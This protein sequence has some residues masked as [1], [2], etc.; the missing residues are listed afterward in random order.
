MKHPRSMAASALFPSVLLV[1]V[2]GGPRVTAQDAGGPARRLD[3]AALAG[4]QLTNARITEAAAMPVPATGS[5][6]VAHCRVSGV[7]DKEIRFTALLPD[8]WNQRFFGGGGGGFSGSVSNQ[9]QASANFGYATIGTDTG[10]QAE[11]TDA[12]WALNNPERQ[13]NYGSLGIHRTTEIAKAVVK[14]YYG[15]DPIHSYFFGCSNG[16]RQG[17]MEA[18]RFPADYDGIVSG[19]PALDFTNIAAA[20]VKHM[21]AV[22]PDPRALADRALPPATLQ[23]LETKVLDS[24]DARDGVKDGILDDPRECR[25]RIADLPACTGDASSSGCVT[26]AQ[27]TIIERLY[28]PVATGG[29]AIYPGQPFGGEGQQGGWQAWI[30]GVNTPPSGPPNRPP[31]LQFAFGTEFFKYFVFGSPGWD[32]SKYDM[33]SWAE[34]GRA[35]CRERV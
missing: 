11:G 34:I 2:A 26:S 9:A 33:A 29:T 8:R 13:T 28:A 3:C 15:T 10:H 4:L 27:R 32:Y 18:Q 24:C 35:S 1:M 23:L 22:F 16:G 21:Q 25:F 30:T 5:I 6:K 19:A 12:S 20:F 7:I 14:A 31:S 17:L